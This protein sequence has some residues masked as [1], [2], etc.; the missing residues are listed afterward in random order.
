MKTNQT[1]DTESS[2]PKLQPMYKVGYR[3]GLEKLLEWDAI[4][5]YPGPNENP[6]YQAGYMGGIHE[7]ARIARRL[8]AEQEEE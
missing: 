7:A 6:S 1:K 3:A 8:L 4:A 5:F 2:D